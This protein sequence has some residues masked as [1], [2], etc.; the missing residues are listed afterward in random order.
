MEKAQNELENQAS[1]FG[2]AENMSEEEKRISFLNR[3]F[4]YKKV[5][6][7]P[8]ATLNNMIELLGEEE[9]KHDAEELE[10]ILS[11]KEQSHNEEKIADC[12]KVSAERISLEEDEDEEDEEVNTKKRKEK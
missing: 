3:Y 11:N 2:E 7:I 12:K 5:R 8:Q 10:D 1:F 4:I 6:D 9:L